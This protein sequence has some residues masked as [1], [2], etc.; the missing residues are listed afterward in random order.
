M[1][2]IIRPAELYTY[3]PPDFPGCREGFFRFSDGSHSRPFYS[4]PEGLWMILLSAAEGLLVEKEIPVLVDQ[5]KNSS[6]PIKVSCAELEAE[7]AA[8]FAELDNDKYF[9]WS[10]LYDQ[11][12]RQARLN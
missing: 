6:L 10:K 7:L 12:A 2:N 9:D 5:L 11:E 3:Q 1:S 8:N 4:R